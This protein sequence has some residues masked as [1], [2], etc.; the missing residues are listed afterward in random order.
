MENRSLV[1]ATPF[2]RDDAGNPYDARALVRK[3][4]VVPWADFAL[5][6]IA[7]QPRPQP[8]PSAGFRHLMQLDE[9]AFRTWR[10]AR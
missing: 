6:V 5:D 7:N 2:F 1:P 10:N 8:V 9:L 4:G 3:F